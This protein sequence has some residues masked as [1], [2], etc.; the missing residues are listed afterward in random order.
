MGTLGALTALGLKVGLAA[1]LALGAAATARY[2][3][4]ARLRGQGC[5]FRPGARSLRILETASLGQHRSLHL[6]DVGD[7]MV[8]VGAT[9]AQITLLTIVPGRAQGHAGEASGHTPPEPP[10]IRLPASLNL[11]RTSGRIPALHTFRAVLHSLLTTHAGIGASW[12]RPGRGSTPPSAPR[13]ASAT[14]LLA[15]ARACL[16]AHGGRAD[17]PSESES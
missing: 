13:T 11:R 17:S 6:V 3:Q 10:G 14:R 9:P 15:A 4:Q 16:P 12:P 2:L 7:R 5:A 8:L 1:A